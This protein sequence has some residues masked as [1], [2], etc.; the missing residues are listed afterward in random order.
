MIDNEINY[1]VGALLYSPA[2]N[3]K[4]AD[5]IISGQFGSNYSIALCLEDTIADTA[6]E[7]ALDQ[8]EKTFK[9]LYAAFTIK[10]FEL[11][12]LFVRVRNP[13]QI[14]SVFQRISFYMDIFSG[15]IFPKYSLI[16][17]DKYNNE[18]LKICKLSTKKIY[19]MPILESEDIVDLA[20]RRN[21]L[22]SL[23][24][25]IDSINEYVLNVR[26]GGNDFSNAFGVRRHIDETIYDILPIAQLLCDILTVFSRDYIVSGP[27]W[28]Y[29]ASEND[30]WSKGLVRELKYDVLNGFVGKT[31][32]HPKQIPIVVESLKVDKNDYADAIEILSWTN[33][34]ELLVGGSVGKER[35]NEVNTHLKWARRIV[36]LAKIYGIRNN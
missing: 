23:K 28:E 18:F 25:K 5:S 9:Q 6:V 29:Y 32:I 33:E 21:V 8:L 27:V 7:H 16:N 15:F 1:S 4:I 13:E 22:L 24:N 20:T 11:P 36:S 35:M 17:A 31:V 3:D 30:E 10:H 14:K 26:V 19:M 12:K 34:K 2:L